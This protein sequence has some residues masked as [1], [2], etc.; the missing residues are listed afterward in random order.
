MAQGK[1][2]R[3]R[4]VEV[5]SAEQKIAWIVFGD[6]AERARIVVVF[7]LQIVGQARGAASGD[8]AADRVLRAV[9]VVRRRRAVGGSAVRL[10]EAIALAADEEEQPV[11]HDGTAEAAAVLVLIKVRE[12]FIH[13][14]KTGRAGVL[15]LHPSADVI[16]IAFRAEHGAF[17]AVRS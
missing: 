10:V 4:G 12:L 17:E 6:V 15:P 2:I 7:G 3:V 8:A 11:A 14:H 16:R 5:H 9:G 13:V 1:G